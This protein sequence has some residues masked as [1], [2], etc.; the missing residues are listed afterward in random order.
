MLKLDRSFLLGKVK[1][2]YRVVSKGES[3]LQLILKKMMEQEII[4]GV[5]SARKEGGRIVPKL[6]KAPSEI[7]L[8]PLNT[9]FGV[10]TL[11]K[12]AIQKYH[13]SRIAVVAPSC[14]MDGLNKTQYYGIGCN[15]VKTAVALKVGILCTGALTQESLN[16]EVLDLLGE[17]EEVERCYYTKEGLAYGLSSGRELLVNVEVH[18]HYVSSAC[19]YCLNL[20]A[21][22][23]DITYIP[24][25]E[26]NVGIFI[27]RS[28]R[29][30]RT[31][32]LLQKEYP[33]LLKFSSLKM[34]DISHV[35]E[36]LK[37]KMIL[38]IDSIL[39][40]VEVGLP[41]SKWDGNRFRKFY[42]VWN[43]IGDFN[44][45]EVF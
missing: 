21:R 28:E 7:E 40:R 1:A 35:E 15:W 25:K 38:N 10:N 22:G 37:K 2:I 29:G 26:E 45:E 20:S 42:R 24:E 16:C 17:R 11:L 6:F 30:G 9:F 5:I 14:V 18:H 39:E 4:D 19:K 44:I 32:G 8:S 43:A 13:L 41:G 33:S 31:L 23:S 34:S 27:I 3:P 36:L 12:K